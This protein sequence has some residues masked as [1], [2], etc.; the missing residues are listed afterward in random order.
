[1]T[2]SLLPE[3]QIH[4]QFL[5][6][7]KILLRANA[8]LFLCP[9]PACTLRLAKGSLPSCSLPESSWTQLPL[10]SPNIHPS[11]YNPGFLKLTIDLL[12]QTI[13]CC[14][15]AVLCVEGYLPAHLA[16][17]HERLVVRLVVNNHKCFQTLPNATKTIL[18][19]NQW[20][21]L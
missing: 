20:L 1:M 15:S 10:L 7:A 4:F 14:A 9:I 21:S 16:S 11:E 13:L 5:P 18:V 17:T 12:N 19:E 6:L 8:P 2:H 3:A